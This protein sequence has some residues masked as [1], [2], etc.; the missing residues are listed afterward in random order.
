LEALGCIF[1]VLCDEVG[2]TQQ[3]FCVGTIGGLDDG[4][5]FEVVFEVGVGR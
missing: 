1:G 5:C 2:D 3:E 4:V